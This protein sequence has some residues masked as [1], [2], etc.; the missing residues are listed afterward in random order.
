M[1]K[2]TPR[3]ELFYGAAD[4]TVELDREIEKRVAEV[5]HR[6]PVP[7]RNP[8]RYTAE[9]VRAQFLLDVMERRE[10]GRTSVVGTPSGWA[11]SLDFGGE[12]SELIVGRGD[13]EPLAI[14]AAFMSERPRRRAKLRHRGLAARL[15]YSVRRV[16]R[17]VWDLRFLVRLREETRKLL[18]P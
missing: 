5:V 18:F 1:R 9:L 10:G 15:D 6:S 4:A 2:K 17:K 3:K 11:C 12:D 16:T 14:C 8:P 13:S 7:W